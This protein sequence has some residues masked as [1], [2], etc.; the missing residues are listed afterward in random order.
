MIQP[1]GKFACFR[2]FL[3]FATVAMDWQPDD[4]TSDF[5][6]FGDGLKVLLVEARVSSRVGLQGTRPSSTGVANCDSNA[7]SPVVDTRQSAQ[8]RPRKIS[9][10]RVSQI[11]QPS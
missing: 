2:R 1:R 6:L 4:P 5:V 10:V 7:D 11:T 9:S 3:A 8:F